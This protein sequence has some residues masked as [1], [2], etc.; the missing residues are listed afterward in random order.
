MI[1]L[2]ILFI[3]NNYGIYYILLLFL[4]HQTHFLS[5]SRSLSLAVY[6]SIRHVLLIYWPKVFVFVSALA[7][8]WSSKCLPNANV[9]FKTYT[10][11]SS[12]VYSESRWLQ[13]LGQQ[14]CLAVPPIWYWKQSIVNIGQTPDCLA[15]HTYSKPFAVVGCLHWANTMD[16]EANEPKT[17][18][19]SSTC[20]GA[21]R[22]C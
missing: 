4:Y 18:E 12:S 17:T 15:A 7:L 20:P 13:L 2:R 9:A 5:L 14:L 11:D 8:A 6:Q 3:Y 19:N 16:S 21:Q 10:N 1:S 22:Q